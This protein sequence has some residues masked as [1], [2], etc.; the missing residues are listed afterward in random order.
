MNKRGQVTV[1]II[2]GIVV[3]V[4][5]GMLVYSGINYSKYGF[6]KNTQNVQLNSQ[7]AK[8]INE[9]IQR[10]VDYHLKEAISL[11]ALQG[12]Y[13]NLPKEPMYTFE[14]MAPYYLID[15]KTIIPGLD[16][17]KDEISIAFKSRINTCLNFSK[18]NKD[19]K[20]NPGS[21]KIKR[22]DITTNDTYIEVDIP[23]EI[24]DNNTRIN[25]KQYNGKVQTNYLYYYNLSKEITNEQMKH[26]DSLC[27]NCANQ[28]L[29]G[30]DSHIQSLEIVDGTDY[31]I[32]Y[33]ITN[34][35]ED[36]PIRS[37]SFA[38]K[39]TLAK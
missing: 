36:E 31:I 11:V 34:D 2:I 24:S 10:C 16:S 5:M 23:V 28:I 8:D 3:L 15:N 7:T 14:K 39:I 21:I 33:Q 29:M 13:Y 35:K 20:Y 9:Q 26:L 37:Y 6:E 22:L 12:G 25:L 32:I 1:F 18:F 27:L 38:H 30:T 4:V 19:V 17:I